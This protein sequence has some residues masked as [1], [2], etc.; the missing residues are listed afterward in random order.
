MLGSELLPAVS[1]PGSR[2][3]D[4]AV[5]VK[6]VVA[7]PV[8]D[9]K[10]GRSLSLGGLLRLPVCLQHVVELGAFLS[11]DDSCPGLGAEASPRPRAGGG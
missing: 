3:P 4:V 9:G 10:W 6:A 8:D 7:P 2:L 11:A 5:A 1:E